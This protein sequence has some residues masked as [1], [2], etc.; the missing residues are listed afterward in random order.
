MQT[1]RKKHKVLVFLT[2]CMSLRHLEAANPSDEEFECPFTES[3]LVIRET[4]AA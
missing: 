4:S 2:I 1:Q 3:A